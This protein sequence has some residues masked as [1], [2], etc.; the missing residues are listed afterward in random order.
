MS[1]VNILLVK[2]FVDVNY[3]CQVTERIFK[4]A[5]DIECLFHFFEQFIRKKKLI[6]GL[7]LAWH[8]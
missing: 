2:E 6:A 8:S 7:Q 4:H 1:Q 3:A 5:R